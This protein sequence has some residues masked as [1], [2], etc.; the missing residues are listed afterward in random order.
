MSNWCKGKYKN[1]KNWNTTTNENY[2]VK[3]VGKE[4]QIAPYSWDQ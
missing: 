1:I 4:T 3:I 2:R